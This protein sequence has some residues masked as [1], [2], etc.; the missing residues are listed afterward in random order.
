MIPWLN[1]RTIHPI[2]VPVHCSIPI[3][4]LCRESA[5]STSALMKS[6][7]KLQCK[8]IPKSSMVSASQIVH[9]QLCCS[10]WHKELVQQAVTDSFPL[11]NGTIWQSRIAIP[12][13][14]GPPKHFCPL[15]KAHEQPADVDKVW[16]RI[17]T[18]AVAQLAMKKCRNQIK[19]ITTKI[20]YS[21][22]NEV[23]PLTMGITGRK[24]S[25][26]VK[27]YLIHFYG[28]D[29]MRLLPRITRNHVS[30][31]RESSPDPSFCSP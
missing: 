4:V 16:E 17:W 1:F 27:R 14:P 26:G 30:W 2:L 13:S 11:K 29:S 18:T 23:I 20:F 28:K 15:F 5:A 19:N 24:T 9:Y 3:F 21:R 6:S 10:G 12:C 31:P 25:S 7:L 22:I 8:K